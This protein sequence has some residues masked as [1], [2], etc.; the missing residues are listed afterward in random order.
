[1][2]KLV[3]LILV[4]FLL[5][6]CSSTKKQDMVVN[7]NEYLTASTLWFQN[8]A[9]SQALYHQAYNL[10]KL[11]LD[12]MLKKKSKAKRAIVLD[13]DETV[14]NNS[15]YQGKLI[16]TKDVYPKYWN[17]WLEA[18]AALALPGAKE[19]LTYARS[20]GFDVFYISN[21][22]KANFDNTKKNLLKAG[23]PLQ[24]DNHLLLLEDESDKTKR[25][26]KVETTHE[27]V[28][29]V[30]DNLNDFT[31]LFEKKSVAERSLIVENNKKQFGDKFI[32]LPNPMYGDWENAVYDYKRN[33]NFSEKEELRL[34][35]L[36]GF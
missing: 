16:V 19:F 36:K 18:E 12:L 9:E 2:K 3:Q 15:P 23:L 21:R 22:K 33:L 31:G 1:M 4:S 7:Q 5:Q 35:S 14:L 29:L 13:I 28:M 11:K 10:A 8:S 30:G 17:E 27:I 32:I 34:K 25:R 20:K 6:A 26:A 24:G